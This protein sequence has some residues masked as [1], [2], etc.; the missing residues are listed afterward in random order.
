MVC[1]FFLV[2][3]LSITTKKLGNLDSQQQR[4]FEVN[5]YGAL[6]NSR[7]HTLVTYIL[8]LYPHRIPFLER[9][10][11]AHFIEPEGDKLAVRSQ[12]YNEYP[13]PHLGWE[14]AFIT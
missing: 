1:I 6:S 10:Y 12:S 11:A 4:Y 7:S 13:Y 2:G 3:K 8:L 14:V 5:V 9:N